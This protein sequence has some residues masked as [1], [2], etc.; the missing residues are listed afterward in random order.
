VALFS[1][2]QVLNIFMLDE[3]YQNR[4][5]G[6][7]QK[8]Q[9]SQG[10]TYMRDPGYF[11]S[12]ISSDVL[13]SPEPYAAMGRIVRKQETASSSLHPGL[14]PQLIEKNQAP[15]I[16]IFTAYVSDDEYFFR[17]IKRIYQTL[18]LQKFHVSCHESEVTENF[19]WQQKDHLKTAQ[20]IILLVSQ[21]LLATD[22]CYHPHLVDAVARHSPGECYVMP[23]LVLP[24]SSMFLE[25]TPFKD[26]EFLPGKNK[27][28]PVREDEQERVL[29]EIADNIIMKLK[30]LKFHS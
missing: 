29:A 14:I 11:D 6:H 7:P 4:E 19:A 3:Q 12:T 2:S 8:R 5:N 23:I 15:P 9:W 28:L 20:I 18:R 13:S 16:E 25:G 27:P 21:N 24:T 22:F 10:T 17:K 30:D 1:S 26:L